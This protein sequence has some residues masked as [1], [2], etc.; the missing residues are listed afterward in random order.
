MTR[1]S[2][3]YRNAHTVRR[4][5]EAREVCGRELGRAQATSE[6]ANRESCLNLVANTR[7]SGQRPR[8]IAETRLPALLI[9]AELLDGLGIEQV[10]LVGNSLGGLFSLWFAL[11]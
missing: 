1:S 4:W 2:S 11:D 8:V 6:L 9:L 7:L 5:E 10:T 3:D